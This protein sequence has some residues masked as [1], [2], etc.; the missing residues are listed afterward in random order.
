MSVRVH[1]KS[2]LDCVTAV[3]VELGTKY[4]T[5]ATNGAG[6]VCDVWNDEGS[7]PVATFSN[8]IYAEIL[9]DESWMLKV[10]Y[11]D[12]SLLTDALFYMAE[13]QGAG[14]ARLT[15]LRDAVHKEKIKRNT[16]G[17]TKK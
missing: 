11:V 8:V 4:V 16:D 13:R 5:T 10:Q 15:D 12:L 1:F 17:L 2:S 9:E 6:L 3:T 7:Y 14:D